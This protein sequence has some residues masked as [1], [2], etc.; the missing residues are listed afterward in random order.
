MDPLRC[1][2]CRAIGLLEQ[3]VEKSKCKCLHAGSGGEWG[4]MWCELGSREERAV[5]C[6]R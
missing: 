1:G 5:L 3:A 4:W 2:S 6:V